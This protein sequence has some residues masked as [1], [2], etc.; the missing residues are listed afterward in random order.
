MRIVFDDSE[1]ET[2]DK[3]LSVS[4]RDIDFSDPQPKE[5]LLELI[6][7]M[8]ETQLQQLLMVAK[9]LKRQ[10]KKA[11]EPNDQFNILK[12]IEDASNQPSTENLASLI[13]DIIRK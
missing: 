13:H 8:N 5:K 2:D 6:E 11:A 4:I 10:P 3:E 9:R 1:M 7:A 12:A